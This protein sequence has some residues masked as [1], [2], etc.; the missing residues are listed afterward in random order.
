MGG[1]FIWYRR[2]EGEEGLSRFGIELERGIKGVST[3]D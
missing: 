1:E 3:F 2:R